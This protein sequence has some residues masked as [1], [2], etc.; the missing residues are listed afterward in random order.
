MR[1]YKNANILQK[2]EE[3]SMEALK[4]ANSLPMWLACGVAVV[5][6]IVQALIFIKKAMD[7][8]PEVGLTK[9]QVNKAVKSSALTSIGPSIVV[10][11]GMLSLLVTVGGPMAWMRLSFI[12]SVMFE[13]IA[14]GIGTSSVGVQLGVDELTPI[15]LTM[16]VWTMILG[17]VGWIVFSTFAADKMEKIQAKVA[18]S[19]PA[20]L[21]IISSAAIIGVFAAMC[22]QKL[23]A[24]N[25]SSLATVLGAAIMFVMMQLTKGEKFAKLREWN[26]TIAILLAMVI[27]A[28]V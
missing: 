4:I 27:T 25:K 2:E 17:S 1:Y 19:N 13:S 20:G 23:V 21:T 22:S 9:E 6:V 28:I 24:L 11:S 14:A 3:F 26:L 10:L 5:L 16:A 12:G 7:A 8:A 15:A 18:G